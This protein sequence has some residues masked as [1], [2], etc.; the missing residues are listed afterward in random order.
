M[1]VNQESLHQTAST[2]V[3]GKKT[4]REPK[5]SVCGTVSQL[6]QGT[7]SAKSDPGGAGSSLQCWIAEVLYG[8][9]NAR[10]HVVRAWLT[11][12][13]DRRESWALIAVPLYR[14]FGIRVAGFL[15]KHPAAQMFFR[16][17]FDLAVRKSH[18][19]F[20]PKMAMARA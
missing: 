1:A 11:E 15:R 14:R 16:P 3:A 13:Y 9:E 10:T 20:A 19:E 6:T 7:K 8:A 4:Y 12:C 2:Q 18:A 17:L 5:L